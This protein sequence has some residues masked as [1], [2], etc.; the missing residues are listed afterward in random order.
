MTYKP[1][2]GPHN[3][4]VLCAFRYCLGRRTYIVSTCVDFLFDYW[5]ELDKNTQK[6]ITDEIREALEKGQA[7]D[8]C[9]VERWQLLLD[10]IDGKYEMTKW[11]PKKIQT[12]DV[13]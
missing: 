7:G 11:G 6:L 12:K 3:F 1:D 9:D 13:K 2:W 8:E 4:L 10:D 5:T